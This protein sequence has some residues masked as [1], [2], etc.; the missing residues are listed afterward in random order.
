MESEKKKK[1]DIKAIYR[2]NRPGQGDIFI[3]SEIS[4]FGEEGFIDR[5]NYFR[6]FVAAC[7]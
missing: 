3:L 4:S 2:Q 7:F 1:N 5:T 6:S